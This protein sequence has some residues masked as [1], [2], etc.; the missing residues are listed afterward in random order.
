MASCSSSPAALRNRPASHDWRRIPLIQ[1]KF[2]LIDVKTAKKAPA[3][4]SV[5]A[6]KSL[7]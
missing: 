4:A 1:R 7:K 2:R 6:R 5:S 3:G